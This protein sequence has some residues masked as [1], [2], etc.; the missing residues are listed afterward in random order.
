M[1]QYED[2]TF[3]ELVLDG[4]AALTEQQLRDLASEFEVAEST[5]MRWANGMVRPHPNVQVRVVKSLEQRAAHRVTLL[6]LVAAVNEA[7]AEGLEVKAGQILVGYFD[8]LFLAGRFEAAAQLLT[9]LDLSYLPPKVVSGVLMISRDAKAE[10]GQ[11]RVRFF[12]RAKTALLTVWKL[13]P[14]QV[15]SICSRHA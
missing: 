10:L 4:V 1:T 3:E 7:L 2:K 13:D 5:I 12:E 11:A 15:E 9:M 8:D 6:E 14:V